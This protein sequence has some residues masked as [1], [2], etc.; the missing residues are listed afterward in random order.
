MAATAIFPWPRRSC[1]TV[2][3]PRRSASGRA[4]NPV[5]VTCGRNSAGSL[6]SAA[7]APIAARTSDK[8]PSRTLLIQAIAVAVAFAIATIADGRILAVT[9]LSLL[10][11]AY[12]GLAVSWQ[13]TIL[14]VAPAWPDRASALYI[15]AFQFG[16]TLVPIIGGAAR[17]VGAVAGFTVSLAAAV[18]GILA[19]A[20]IQLECGPVRGDSSD[21]PALADEDR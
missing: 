20:Q 9:W 21:E 3:I 2:V 17:S 18:M 13:S 4:S 5:R 7:S 1:L 12:S 10:A 14:R 16:I 19:T 11:L 8:W 15:V 6:W